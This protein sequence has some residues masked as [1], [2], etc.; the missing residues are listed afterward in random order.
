MKRADR[1]LFQGMLQWSGIVLLILLAVAFLADLIA[2]SS[3]PGG[4][5]WGMGLLFRYCALQLP[6]TAYT[7]IP[8]AVLIG[9]LLWMSLLNSRSELTALRMAGWS[10]WRL[11]RPLLWVGL[12]AA[13]LMLGLSEWVV[14]RT[15]LAAEML[16]ANQGQTRFQ[17]LGQD[18]L[19]LRQDHALVHIQLVGS[20]GYA[21]RQMEIFYPEPGMV[22]IQR[23][24][25]A[26][27]AQYQNGSWQLADVREY[28]LGPQQI[29]IVDRDHQAWSVALLPQTLRAFVHRPRTMSL[30]D[31]WR[32]YQNLQG[33]VLAMNRFALAFWQRIS[34]PWVGLIMI[35][36]VTPLIVRNPRGGSAYFWV[37][38]GLLLGLSFHFF[39]QM[40]GFISAAGGIPPAVAVLG[41]M[42]LY[43]GLAWFLQ[44]RHP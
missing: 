43:G 21:L 44:Y 36:L 4:S 13:L 29:K 10:L 9:A 37:M 27:S 41:P 35:L 24:L 40:S 30:G 31:L 33:G 8:L 2:K 16:W 17:S 23:L 5:H 39:S 18:G 7:I 25:T 6:E 28:I 34:Y 11:Q 38:I 22:G 19:W 1:L 20:R 32:S 42:T 15:S 14:P 12:L 3:G 26:K